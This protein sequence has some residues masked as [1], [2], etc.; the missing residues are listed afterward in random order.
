MAPVIKEKPKVIKQTKE[1]KVVIEVRIASGAAPKVQ[2]MKE[3][4]VIREDS[5]HVVRI[6]EV[7]KGE[8]AVALEI[9]KAEKLDKGTYKVVA[10]NEKGECTSQAVTVDVEGK[11]KIMLIIMILIN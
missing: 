1:R 11:R 4:T 9:D 5:R 2:W 6:Q 7:S 3:S 8:Y 10:K